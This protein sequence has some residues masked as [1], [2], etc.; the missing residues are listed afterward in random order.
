MRSFALAALV[1]S[2]A[3]SC[4]ERSGESPPADAPAPSPHRVFALAYPTW[5]LAEAVGGP[6]TEVIDARPDFDDPEAWQPARE[7]VFTMK[8]DATVVLV[9]GPFEPWFREENVSKFLL[10]RMTE[11]LEAVTIARPGGEMNPFV[12]L[13]PESLDLAAKGLADH[14]ARLMPSEEAGFRKRQAA[15]SAKLSELDD[16]LRALP[17]RAVFGSRDAFAYA[18]RAMGAEFQHLA[19]EP[20]AEPT[21]EEVQR[22]R[23]RMQSFPARIVLVPRQPG[24]AMAAALRS[25]GLT[26]VVFDLMTHRSEG[27]RA[28]GRD[29]FGIYGA[30]VER[31]ARALP[32]P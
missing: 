26:P 6:A 31:L 28:A 10:Y 15:L 19:L 13:E 25:V 12:W 18:A 24:E 2:G 4:T 9:G 27:D 1:A 8:E 3:A 32:S 21:P 20:D 5:F 23:R 29:Y 30:N 14:F 22:W 7:L 11:P 16:E 17:L